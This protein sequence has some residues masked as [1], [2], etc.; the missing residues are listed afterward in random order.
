M[1]CQQLRS[2]FGWAAR[3][4]FGVEGTDLAQVWVPQSLV[5][6]CVPVLAANSIS[7]SILFVG[8][9]LPCYLHC[10]RLAFAILLIWKWNK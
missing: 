1:A 6:R 3:I 2:R 5:D 9:D 8:F 10:L 7:K 4:V